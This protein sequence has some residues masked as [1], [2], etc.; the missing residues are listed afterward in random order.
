MAESMRN[1]DISY[2]ALTEIPG[3]FSH[4]DEKKVF[5]IIFIILVIIIK[6]LS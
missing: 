1:L 4:L 2:C 5:I 3:G 6:L